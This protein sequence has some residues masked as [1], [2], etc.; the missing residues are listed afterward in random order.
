MI[1]GRVLDNLGSQGE[2]EQALQEIENLF[3]TDYL[4][5]Q[6][7]KNLLSMLWNRKDRLSTVELFIIGK[8]IL[9]IK[10]EDESWLK[11]TVRE[12][13]RSPDKTK[14]LFSEIIY[15]GM[16]SLPYSKITPAARK[17][18][19]Y[20]FSITMKNSFTQFISIK[21]VDVSDEQKKFQAGCK[22]IRAKWK[23]RLRFFHK[24][25]GLTV[26]SKEPI[27]ESDFELIIKSIKEVKKIFPQLR[28]TARDGL[29]MLITR[30][31]I[32]Y[33][34]SP[35]HTSDMVLI[36]CPSPE[37]EKKRYAN[38]VA[39]AAKNLISHTKQEINALRIIFI[40]VNVH[41]DYT[42][43]QNR[44]IQIINDPTSKIDCIMT[45]QPSYV[46]DNEGNSIIHH[47]FK[48]EATQRFA[49]SLGEDAPAKI[50]I[51]LGITSMS[52]APIQFV[53]PINGKVQEIQSSDYIFQ[54]GDIYKLGK[55]GEDIYINSPAPGIK[56]HGVCEINNQFIAISSKLT[57]NE[58]NL[59]L[60]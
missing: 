37:S 5:N 26:I 14:G 35:I 50:T 52:Q 30:L 3:G 25:L 17:N 55:I 8:C 27:K 13:K 21:N 48:L 44:A 1:Q 2:A 47:C 56:V 4:N 45:Y 9:K 15:F 16:L 42:R 57:P 34:V 59:I 19:G 28:I 38:K 32:N 36:Y 22:R 54:Q 29:D 24:N 7:E 31:P 43:I 51:P 60:I 33:E 6:S 11:K 40:R 10:E 18:P 12:I 58:E 23:E 41:A 39:L 49:M 53:D 20:D 46:R